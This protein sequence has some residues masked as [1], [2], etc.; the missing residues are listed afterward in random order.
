MSI[1]QT[2]LLNRW[3][4]K[5][6]D[7][8]FGWKKENFE[9]MCLNEYIALCQT[10]NQDHLRLLQ[11]AQLNGYIKWREKHMDSSPYEFLNK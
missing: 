10:D 11:K 7:K 3:A 2:M 4:N 9:R 5:Q 8:R 6:L 1:W